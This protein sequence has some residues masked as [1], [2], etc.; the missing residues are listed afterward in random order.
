MFE[1]WGLG[2]T[3]SQSV[4][5]KLQNPMQGKMQVRTLGLGSDQKSKLEPQT[6]KFSVF[7]DFGQ[8]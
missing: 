7:A 4:N 6:P 1:P 8:G 5:R 3:K 2:Q